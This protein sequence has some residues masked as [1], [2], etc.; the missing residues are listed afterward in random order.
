MCVGWLPD[1]LVK[2]N[3]EGVETAE[4]EGKND[5]ILFD[6]EENWSNNFGATRAIR[7]FSLAAE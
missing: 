7:V 6:L 2:T 1:L 3:M 4:E 5:R